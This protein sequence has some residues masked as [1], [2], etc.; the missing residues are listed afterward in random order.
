MSRILLASASPRRRELLSSI[1]LTY[2]TVP[3]SRLD[4]AAVLGHML[5][6]LPER[7]T[8]NIASAL[9]ELARLKGDEPSRANPQALVISAD[10]EVLLE[11]DCLGKP[12]DAPAAHAMLSRLSGRWHEVVTA[13]CLQRSS[14]SLLVRE[15]CTSR[16]RFVAL[17]KEE[18]ERYVELE[19]PFDKAGAY[20]IQGRGALII[21]RIEG[22]YSNIVGLPLRTLAGMLRQAGIELI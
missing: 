5:S 1:G 4:E 13:L 16:V 12:A 22:D 20:A 3:G 19:Q 14:D 18:I 10:T 6:V 21:E 9:R 15:H 2:E 17:R 7:S 11:G 8:A